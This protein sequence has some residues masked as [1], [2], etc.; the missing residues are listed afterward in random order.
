MAALRSDMAPNL[1]LLHYDRTAWVVTN[2]ML[3]SPFAFPPSA[4][5]CRKPLST[6]AR[7]AGWVG[8]FIVLSRIPA[9]A[10]IGVVRDGEP[11]APETD[12]AQY[13]RLLPLKQI[14]VPERGWTL[15]VLSAARALGKSEFT[16]VDMYSQSSVLQARHPENCHITDKIRQQLQILRDRG[17]V[18]HVARGR[19][20]L[21]LG[22]AMSIHLLFFRDLG[23]NGAKRD[24]VPKEMTHLERRAVERVRRARVKA[25]ESVILAFVRSNGGPEEILTTKLCDIRAIANAF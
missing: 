22:Q 15:D 20:Q 6:T 24:S 14:A 13:Q 4:I 7:R 17:L 19:W 1:F 21:V 2:L 16:N 5:E 3:V 9:D 12:R 25:P 10:R 18:R 23:P 8:C 11:V